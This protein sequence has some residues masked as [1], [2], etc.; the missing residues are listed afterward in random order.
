MSI[1]FL[2]AI[3]RD[4]SFD[5][6]ILDYLLGGV[7]GGLF[8]GF[9]GG[10][11]FLLVAVIQASLKPKAITKDLKPNQ[12]I[13]TTMK[14]A[15]FTDV[16]IGGYCIALVGK[17]LKWVL[18]IENIAI[19]GKFIAIFAVI[20]QGVGMFFGAD[21][22]DGNTANEINFGIYTGLIFGLAGGLLFGLRGVLMGGVYE[23]IKHFMIRRVLKRD[24]L[25]PFSN[26]WE[27]KELIGFLDMMGDRI[28]LQR[29]GASWRF[30]HKALEEHFASQSKIIW[31]DDRM[32]RGRIG[33]FFEEWGL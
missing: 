25:F 22:S 17:I 29:T 20:F 26:P 27:D 2:R 6:N 24:G 12:A 4:I 23:S 1:Y 5:F 28:L 10:L 16:F 8:S 30:I 19:L 21:F 9:F 11:F 31:E 3:L 18:S 13:Y 33:K 7:L 15:I 32:E 14:F